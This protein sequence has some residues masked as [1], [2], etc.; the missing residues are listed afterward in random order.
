MQIALGNRNVLPAISTV[1]GPQK[2]SSIN[3]AA[4]PSTSQFQVISNTPPLAGA[5]LQRKT[6]GIQL[7]IYILHWNKTSAY[8]WAFF[9]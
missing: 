1:V 3:G 4:L 7:K 9:L 6:Y 5:V 2:E 8:C